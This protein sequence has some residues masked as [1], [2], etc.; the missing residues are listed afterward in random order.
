MR[1]QHKKGVLNM[2]PISPSKKAKTK[3]Q[4][5]LGEEETP[6]E[7][8]RPMSEEEFFQALDLDENPK[9]TAKKAP[10]KEQPPEPPKPLPGPP[11]QEKP[12]FFSV[13]FGKKEKEPIDRK[14]QEIEDLKAKI[15]NINKGIEVP[16]PMDDFSQDE[17][18]NAR[19]EQEKK[20]LE[21]LKSRN[22]KEY[23][24]KKEHIKHLEEEIQNLG[25]DVLT[26]KQR[27]AKEIGQIKT[28]KK[29]VDGLQ[30]SME[31]RE[32][33]LSAKEEQYQ[34][35]LLELQKNEAALKEQKDSL[36]AM[37][38][39]FLEKQKQFEEEVGLVLKKKE[40]EASVN[41]LTAKVSAL[42]KQELDILARVEVLTKTQL[43]QLLSLANQFIQVKQF[44]R[45]KAVYGVIDY[46]FASVHLQPKDA[47]EL[48]LVIQQLYNTINLGL[49]GK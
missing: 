19:M 15:S 18:D 42:K 4:P 8:V 28:T 7:S 29:A 30:K 31:K 46:L 9:I 16:A 21:E 36:E 5:P 24:L 6:P 26:K 11:P 22:A 17:K 44:E 39:E 32:Q 49:I 25:K 40:L 10:P 2:T 47:H 12:G 23:S 20:L 45:A 27:L 43:Q 14:N 1:F 38:N 48:K 33:A 37:Y 34:T 13:L 41:D 3:Q 35:R